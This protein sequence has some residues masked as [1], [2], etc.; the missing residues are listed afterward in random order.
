MNSTHTLDAPAKINIG[1]HVLS[2]RNDNYHNIE[3]I[4]YPLN[5]TDKITIK[6]SQ[7]KSLTSEIIFKTN[8]KLLER[9]SGNLCVK[10]ALYFLQ[11]FNFKNSFKLN[12]NLIKRI[13]IGAGLGGGSSDAAA[14]LKILSSVYK[15]NKKQKNTLKQTALKIGS[16]V[17]YFLMGNA[18]YAG[19]RGEML[20]PLPGFKIDYDILIVNPGIH[21]STAWAYKKLNIKKSKPKTL[22]RIKIYSEKYNEKFTNDFEKVVFAEYPEIKN[23]KEMMNSFGAVYF[24]MSGSGSTVFGFFKG[25]ALKEAKKYFSEKGYFTFVSK[26]SS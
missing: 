1:L 13:P 26:N 18:A 15:L 21:I 19:S 9:R 12:I 8:N 2:K 20:I 4:F 6:I 10:A 23:I 25:K 3:T 5:L 17:P 14:V 11:D 22:N 16:D 7:S 24:S